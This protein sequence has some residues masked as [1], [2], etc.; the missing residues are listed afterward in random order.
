MVSLKKVAPGQGGRRIESR[1]A[2]AVCM[3][4]S[5]FHKF[6]TEGKRSELTLLFG[7]TTEGRILGSLLDF[8]G[9]FT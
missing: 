1:E 7:K 6:G 8:W 3:R 4:P 5:F 2:E 9:P